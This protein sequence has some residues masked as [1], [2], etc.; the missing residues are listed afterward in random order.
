MARSDFFRRRLRACWVFL[1][2]HEKV[3]RQAKKIKSFLES[4]I[5]IKGIST[6]EP[7]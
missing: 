7:E 1:L 4:E 6:G 2:T 5:K 3:A